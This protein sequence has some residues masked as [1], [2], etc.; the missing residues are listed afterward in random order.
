MIIY[1]II[2]YDFYVFGQVVFAA[3]QLFTDQEEEAGASQPEVPSSMAIDVKVLSRQVTV[4]IQD[5]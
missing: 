4:W 3:W 1:K 2:G 5:L